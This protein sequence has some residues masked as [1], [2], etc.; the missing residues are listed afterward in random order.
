MLAS[1]NKLIASWAEIE[2]PKNRS[3][4]L[5]NYQEA[6]DFEQPYGCNIAFFLSDE[7]SQR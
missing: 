2:N 5:T 4:R 6:T 3:D 1:T 7:A